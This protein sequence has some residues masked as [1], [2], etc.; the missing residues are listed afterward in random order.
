MTT[1][2]ELDPIVA[3]GILARASLALEDEANPEA[4]FVVPNE[5]AIRESVLKEIYAQLGSSRSD[6]VQEITER[7]LELLD[8]EVNRLLGLADVDAALKRLAESGDLSSDFYEIRIGEHLSGLFGQ[9]GELEP[10]LIEATIRFPEQ[11]QHFGRQKSAREPSLVSIFT[12]RFR[13]KWPFKSFTMVVAAHRDNLILTVHQAWRMYDSEIKIPS[14]ARPV[15]MLEAFA[16]HYGTNIEINGIKAPFFLTGAAPSVNEIKISTRSGRE[17]AALFSQFA[18]VPLEDGK[19]RAALVMAVDVG[20]YQKVL[21]RMSV[22][23]DEILDDVF[24]MPK[25]TPAFM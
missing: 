16:R 3:A 6:A 17:S 24:R 20:E 23:E 22:T 14:G 10:R 7:V 2:S 19:P 8:E 9:A 5:Q 12:R 15:E 1:L 4:G 11:E 13:T 21:E 18:Q 25:R